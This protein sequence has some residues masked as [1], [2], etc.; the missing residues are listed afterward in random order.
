M[1][2]SNFDAVVVGI[3]GVI[4]LML[5]VTV[6]VAFPAMLMFGVVHSYW[7][8]LPAFGFWETLGVIILAR[9]VL[10]TVQVNRS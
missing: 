9:L 8:W 10:P 4:A 5:I 6:I 7:A 1:S 3:V 2:K